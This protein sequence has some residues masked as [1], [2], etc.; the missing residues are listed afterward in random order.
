MTFYE[1]FVEP[2]VWLYFLDLK[3]QEL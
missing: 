2:T 1:M 3:I